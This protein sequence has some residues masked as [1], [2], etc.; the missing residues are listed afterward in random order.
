[1]IKGI[2]HV[3]LPMRNVAAML[4]FYR[5]IGADIREEV[6]GFLHAA[7]LGTNKI[8]L[9]MPDAW[10]S[11]EFDLRGPSATPGCGD[12]CFVWDGPLEQ[13][14]AMLANADVETIEGPVDSVLSH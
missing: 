13:L 8:N 9:Y 10:Q 4:T 12:L 14:Q 5:S 11:S 3:A 6:P 7:Y 1:M 2:D